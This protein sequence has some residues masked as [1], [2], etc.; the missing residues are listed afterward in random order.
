MGQLPP[1][2]RA[3]ANGDQVTLNRFLASGAHVA[4]LNGAVTF[5]SIQSV[6]APYG[7]NTRQITV[8][9]N[10]SI[11]SAGAGR[12]AAPV[13]TAPASMPVTY[14]MTVVR[15]GTSWYVQSIGASPQSPGPP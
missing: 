1:F 7:G 4:G 10:W 9:V 8:V 6:N 11:A 14:L 15:Q 3:Y 12:H 2:F 5:G 13:A